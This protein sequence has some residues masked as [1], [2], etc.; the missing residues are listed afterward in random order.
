MA[1][2]ADHW[3]T[4]YTTKSADSVSWYQVRPEASI[5]ALARLDLG[6]P[7]S[8]ID[9]G[10]GA[11]NLVDAL[12]DKAWCDLTVLD[13]AQPALD[14]AKARLG[15]RAADVDWIA[16]DITRWR[17]DRTYAIWHDRAVFHFLTE[18][19]DRVG[20]RA[21]LERGLAPG[22]ALLRATFALGGPERCSG[23]PIMQYS[24]ESLS[25]ELGATFRLDASWREDHMTPSGGLQAFNWCLFR[26]ID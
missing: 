2:Q 17:P 15:P 4:V 14:A 5:E 26:R 24:P 22:G 3:D 8:L 20:Y 11:S 1:Q 12:L 23:L 7:L 13:I 16:T 21:A 10:G 25:A 6:E 18:P 9:V 19:A